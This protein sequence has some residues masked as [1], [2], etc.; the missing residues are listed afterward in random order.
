MKHYVTT[1]KAQVKSTCNDLGGCPKQTKKS[2]VY[3]CICVCVLN[4][5]MNIKKIVERYIPTDYI[6]EKGDL[7]AWSSK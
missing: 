6:G 5:F 3:I 4:D 2:S 7:S 1:K